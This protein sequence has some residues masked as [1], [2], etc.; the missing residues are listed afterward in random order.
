MQIASHRIFRLNLVRV[1]LSHI[2]RAIASVLAVVLLGNSV[3]FAAG[4]PKVK[5]AMDPAMLKQTLT[6]RGIGKGVKVKELDGTIVV[7]T[8]TGIQDGNFQVAPK[9]ATQS[10]TIQDANVASIHN[11][12]LSTGAKIGIGIGIGVGGLLAFML[13]DLASHPGI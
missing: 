11:S 8:L 3:A 12:G 4:A 5:T 2:F 9:S 7:G 1:R 13:I 6:T 10:I